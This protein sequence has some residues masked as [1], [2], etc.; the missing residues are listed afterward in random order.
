MIVGF[1]GEVISRILGSFISWR[2]VVELVAVRM[3]HGH[4]E[5]RVLRL[6]LDVRL[7]VLGRYIMIPVRVK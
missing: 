6:R 2:Q 5:S 4:R 1:E 3:G 7:D